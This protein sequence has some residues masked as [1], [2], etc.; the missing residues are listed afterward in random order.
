MKQ[1]SLESGM[2]CPG[3]QSAQIPYLLGNLF[4]GFLWMKM[5]QLIRLLC[6]V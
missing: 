1:I 4:E 3:Q 5:G 2:V 6:V